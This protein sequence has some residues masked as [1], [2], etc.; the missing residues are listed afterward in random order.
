MQ[1]EN[2]L[3]R[4][5]QQDVGQEENDLNAEQG[6]QLILLENQLRLVEARNLKLDEENQALK[7]EVLSKTETNPV[8]LTKVNAEKQ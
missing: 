7:E 6:R 4:S 2:Q 1:H 3:L 5:N 8:E